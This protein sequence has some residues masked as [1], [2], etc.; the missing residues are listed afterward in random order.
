VDTTAIFE[1]KQKYGQ[2]DSIGRRCMKILNDMLHH[3]PNAEE[4]ETSLKE[5]LCL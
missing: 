4:P 3:S 5:I 1:P 2:A